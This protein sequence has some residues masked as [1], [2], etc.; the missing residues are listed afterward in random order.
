MHRAIRGD[1]AALPRAVEALAPGDGETIAAILRWLEFIQRSI[2]HHHGTEDSWVYPR[3][4]ER[5]PSFAAARQALEADHHA[6]D[7]ALAAARAGLA[8]LGESTRF[9]EDRAALV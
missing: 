2:E 9:A 6:L 1:L 3:L 7:P 5:D 8:Q 4:E